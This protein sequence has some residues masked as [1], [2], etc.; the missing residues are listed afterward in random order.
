MS[1]LI[2]KENKIHNVSK[3]HPQHFCYDS[4][5]LRSGSKKLVYFPTSS[6]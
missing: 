4:T 5:M 3:N 2:W 6:D 1:K